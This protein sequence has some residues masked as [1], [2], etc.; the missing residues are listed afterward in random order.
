MTV[1]QRQIIPPPTH[2]R[3]HPQ[4]NTKHLCLFSSE[5]TVLN[6]KAGFSVA[7]DRIILKSAKR[8]WKIFFS[9]FSCPGSSIPDL[10]QSV[11]QEDK[12]TKTQKHK[13][14]TKRLKDKRTKR[15][16]PKRKFN[17]A[18][19][20]QFPTLVSNLVRAEG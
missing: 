19:S 10:G 13:K 11:R 6:C 8:L 3:T 12:K 20:G 16:R 18:T 4:T 9:V 7:F 2:T 5:V 17:V 14:K 1:V 15:Q